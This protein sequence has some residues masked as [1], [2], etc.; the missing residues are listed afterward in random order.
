MSA[1]IFK[2]DTT[3]LQRLGR[4]LK[5]VRPEAYKR[6]RLVMKAEAK[7]MADKARENASFSTRI[8]QT[9]Q[10]STRGAL[11]AV[12]K[13]GSPT[14]PKGT[15][16][17]A[18]MGSAPHAK[19]IEHAGKTGTFRHPLYGTKKWVSQAAHPFLKPAVMEHLDDTARALAGALEA[20]VEAIHESEV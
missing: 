10:A 9:I 14:Q 15:P 3:S 6:T 2:T 19:P 18:Q 17:S 12:V 16:K 13:G 5:E 7:K 4:R 1:P 8:P 11:N 20:C